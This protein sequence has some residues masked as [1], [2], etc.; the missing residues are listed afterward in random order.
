MQ[1]GREITI[2]IDDSFTQPVCDHCVGFLRIVKGQKEET[3]QPC[4]TGTFAKL[5]KVYGIVTAGHVLKPLEKNE[6]IGLVRFPGV[7]P[8]IQNFRLDLSL[9][10]RLV[11]WNDKDGDAPDVAFLKIPE[12][13]ARNLEA[14]GAVFYNLELERK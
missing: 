6:T 3:A 9:T 7:K 12:L 14:L 10:D 8:A 4:G 11:L 1:N 13:V 5:G 2:S